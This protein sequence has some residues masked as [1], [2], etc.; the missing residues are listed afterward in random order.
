M[1]SKYVYGVVPASA[2]APSSSGIDGQ[3]LELVRQDDVAALVSA[4]PDEDLTMGREAMTAH[5]RVLEEAHS[6]GTVLPMRFGMVMSGEDEV[7]T[8]LLDL[9]H[10][11]LVAQLVELQG[12]AELRLRATYEE[13][14]L[15][16][17]VVEGDRD[18]ARLRESLRDAPADAT[19][20]GRIQLGELVAQA[21][22]RKRARDA[23]LIIDALAP[24]ALALDVTPPPHERVVLAASFLVESG[25]I[26]EFDLAV[27]QI[28]EAQAGRM[29]FKYTG[30]LPPHSFVKLAETV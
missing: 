14:P 24:L 4:A 20:Y 26:P 23:A 10:D 29:R 7:Q 8:N 16:R 21:V 27:G 3:S 12:K 2:P 22:E 5:A 28:G 19:Y 30:P 25:R 18:V 9:H 17:E 13:E 1:A 6:R 15:L 11:A